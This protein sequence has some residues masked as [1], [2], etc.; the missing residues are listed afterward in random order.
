[1]LRKRGSIP[2]FIGVL[3]V[4][5]LVA[6]CQDAVIDADHPD[7]S[8]E[9]AILAKMN[10]AFAE[11]G[12]YVVPEAE[13]AIFGIE[14]LDV[15]ALD[16][17]PGKHTVCDRA[18][19]P[20]AAGTLKARSCASV[21]LVNF[22]GGLYNQISARATNGVRFSSD[23]IPVPRESKVC[24]ITLRLEGSFIAENDCEAEP[25]SYNA[26]NGFVALIP[27]QDG[28]YHYTRTSQHTWN[29]A[30]QLFAATTAVNFAVTP[31]P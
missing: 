28:P 1:M 21:E 3:L 18:D 25:Y 23:A 7:A 8:Q 22:Q 4:G 6:G 24:A 27:A 10:K 15:D 14:P 9:E 26:S 12:H 17:N 30:G 13:Y 19:V 31:I 20:F 2:S 11:T 16:E 5:L 29:V